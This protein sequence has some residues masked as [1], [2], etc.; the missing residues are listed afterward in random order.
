MAA[1]PAEPGELLHFAL[2]TLS[3]Q[4]QIILECKQGSSENDDKSDVYSRLEFKVISSC[5]YPD[6]GRA[7]CGHFEKELGMN[8]NHIEPLWT[9]Y[10]P[11]LTY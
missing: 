10:G 1:W 2:I 3:I 4:G 8:L 5:S 6:C 7:N 9:I 11:F